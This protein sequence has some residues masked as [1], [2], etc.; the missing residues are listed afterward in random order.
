VRKFSCRR[1]PPLDG[2]E[3]DPQIVKSPD[4]EEQRSV[5]RAALARL[6]YAVHRRVALPGCERAFVLV[7]ASGVAAR[8]I[9]AN[10]YATAVTEPLPCCA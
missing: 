2:H 1:E 9:L 10:E 8:R 5:Q 6:A 7:A 4:N 3:A